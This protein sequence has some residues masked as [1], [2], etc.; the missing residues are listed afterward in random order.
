MSWPSWYG[1]YPPRRLY[2]SQVDYYRKLLELLVLKG[3]ARIDHQVHAAPSYDMISVYVPE[4]IAQI[5]D[6]KG[7][8]TALTEVERKV[9]QTGGWEYHQTVAAL[10]R[11]A[12]Q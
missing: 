11:I 4:W 7:P 3:L 5:M 10:R 12:E 8:T 6:K 9:K 2:G 1:S